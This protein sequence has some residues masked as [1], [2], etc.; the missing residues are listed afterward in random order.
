MRIAG[1][2]KAG[3]YPIHSEVMAVIAKHL[4]TRLPSPEKPKD[5][6]QIIDPCAGE[7]LAIKQLAC[8]LAIPNDHVY[9]VELDGKRV[10][11]IKEN[12]PGA[13]VLG[14][15]SF[16]GGIQCTGQSFGLAYVNP[17]F[18]NEY[19]GGRREEQAFCERAAGL[20]VPHGVMVLVCP[21]HAFIGN[22]EFVTYFDMHFEDSAIYKFL[23]GDGADGKRIRSYKEIVVFG[24][25]RRT[26][27]PRDAVYEH[28]VFYKMQVQFN[29]YIT[30][31][32]V[33]ALGQ[34]QP[35]SWSR[36]TPS[37]S[38]E[39]SIRTFEV[40]PAW[41]P[42]TFKKISFTDEELEAEVKNSPL[43]RHLKE[44][45]LSPPSEPPLPL[46]KGHLGLILA[47]GMLNGPV[48]GPHGVHIVRGSSHKKEYLN[49]E[50][51]GSTENPETGAVT[52]KDV[53][54]EKPITVI[55]IVDDRGI[56]W[57]YSNEPDE[58]TL[59]DDE[60]ENEE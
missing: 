26:P 44:V 30:I 31:G 17:P 8:A 5:T 50:A 36:G 56:I 40:P 48:L 13:R 32:S 29:D 52:T 46:D 49:M 24:R 14:P 6:L 10:E 3:F 60:D 54:S 37:N 21:M 18:D 47:S 33:P 38:R 28:G 34:T 59:D 2:A 16:I 57:G 41:R 20:L 25:K 45:I 39:Q 51:S 27:I 43:N 19:G 7:G 4:Y 53:F 55:R 35:S 22:R 42:N 23:D 12:I 1:Q 58:A 15:V 11:R 9:A